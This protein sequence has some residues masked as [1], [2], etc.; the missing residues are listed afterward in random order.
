MAVL[1]PGILKV[2]TEESAPSCIILFFRVEW[3]CNIENYPMKKG[4]YYVI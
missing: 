1:F 4:D 2:S 3:F